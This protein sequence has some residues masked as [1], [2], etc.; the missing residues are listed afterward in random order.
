MG[1]LPDGGAGGG[2]NWVLLCR[3]GLL[4]K[5]LTQLSAEGRGCMPSLVVVWS[6]MTQP[7]GL[8]LCGWVNGDL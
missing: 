5:V 8:R 2:K 6:E 3:Q 7:W 1:E 4:S